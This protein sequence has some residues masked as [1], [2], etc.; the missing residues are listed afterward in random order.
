MGMSTFRAVSQGDHTRTLRRAQ[1]TIIHGSEGP[2]APGPPKVPTRDSLP[3]MPAAPQSP[4]RPWDFPMKPSQTE[5]GGRVS[6]QA[7]CPK[8]FLR[9]L[10]DG[11]GGHRLG[12]LLD[13]LIPVLQRCTHDLARVVAL[14]RDG[15]GVHRHT[16]RGLLALKN[17]EITL[18]PYKPPKIRRRIKP[19]AFVFLRVGDN[20]IVAVVLAPSCEEVPK[21]V[22]A[23]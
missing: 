1:S 6:A 8:P 18:P 9:I 10:W 19:D 2:V 11:V 5:P 16:P 22:S 13:K 20:D 3:A 17:E 14:R 23:D 7:D 15:L 21:K 4:S 12:P